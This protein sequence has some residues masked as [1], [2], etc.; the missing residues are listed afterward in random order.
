[1]PSIERGRL[2][3]I[4]PNPAQ[5]EGTVSAIGTVSRKEVPRNDL[6]PASQPPILTPQHLV[7]QLTLKRQQITVMISSEDAIEMVP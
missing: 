5:E 6:L 4:S 7:H 3:L 1:M 2:H